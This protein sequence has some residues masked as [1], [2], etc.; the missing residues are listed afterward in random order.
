MQKLYIIVAIF[1]LAVAGYYYITPQANGPTVLDNTE[2]DI[3]ED[4]VME[5]TVDTSNWQTYRNEEYGFEFQY[6]DG[7]APVQFV[8]QGP[9]ELLTVLFYDID[10]AMAHPEG[11]GGIDTTSYLKMKVWANSI[12]E[13]GDPNDILINYTFAFGYPNEIRTRFSGISL[14]NGV[15]FIELPIGTTYGRKIAFEIEPKNVIVEF[16]VHDSRSIFED[17][18]VMDF[19]KN[20]FSLF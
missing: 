4:I 13:P 16:S 5:D 3:M 2:Q 7:L 6:P 20:S 14:S 8:R 18:S 9:G 17:Q 11:I 1:I 15:R 12:G 10:T 19:V